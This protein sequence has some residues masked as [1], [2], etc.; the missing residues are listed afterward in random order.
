MNH[1][2]NEKG[3]KYLSSAI[4]EKAAS[5]WIDPGAWFR[6]A[7]DHAD[8]GDFQIEMG[9]RYTHTGR[10]EIIAT[11]QDWFDLVKYEDE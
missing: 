9:A 4:M 6:E 8:M 1:V 3:Q 10:P 5:H 7:E 11:D 2:L